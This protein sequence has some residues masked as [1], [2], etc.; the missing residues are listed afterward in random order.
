MTRLKNVTYLDFQV[1]DATRLPFNGNE[2]DVAIA[3][4]MH[5]MNG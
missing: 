4:A 3:Q 1:A 5:P 2:F